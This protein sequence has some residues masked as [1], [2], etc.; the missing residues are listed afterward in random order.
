MQKVHLYRTIARKAEAYVNEKSSKFYAYSFQLKSEEEASVYLKQ[1]RQ[2]FP[3]A[4]HHC[5]AYVC[6]VQGQFV[7]AS[8]DGEPA[9]SAG[10]P[11]LHAIQSLGLTETMVVVVRYFGGKQLGVR[12][13]IDV[14]HQATI[15]VLEASGMIERE[16]NQAVIFH[17]RYDQEPQ[18]QRV[19]KRFALKPDS[20]QPDMKGL[21]VQVNVPV[22]RIPDVL[23]EIKMIA[24]E[25]EVGSIW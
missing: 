16:L 6:G 2:Q 10:K 9:G 22:S 5:S 25:V 21:T 12:G 3:D 15:Q 13:L 24:D 8:D 20:H 17:Y 14:Y 1:L 4:N 18:V 19:W 7:K 23:E 11:I